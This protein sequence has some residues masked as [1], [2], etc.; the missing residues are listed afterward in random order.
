MLLFFL[1]LDTF[2]VSRNLSNLEN[3]AD[4]LTEKLHDMK[5]TA[6]AKTILKAQELYGSAEANQKC[7][8]ESRAQ[9]ESLV[10]G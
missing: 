7:Y 3:A 8:R 9:L 4:A 6:C 2:F 10:S 5:I 1:N